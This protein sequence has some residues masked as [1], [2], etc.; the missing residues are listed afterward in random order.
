MD[1]PATQKPASFAHHAVLLSHLLININTN[2]W[3]G[4]QFCMQF[5]SHQA[6]WGEVTFGTGFNNIHTPALQQHTWFLASHQINTTPT[7]TDRRFSLPL[8]FLFNFD[9]SLGSVQ[10][11]DYS[12]EN[13]RYE[14]GKNCM[15]IVIWTNQC[16]YI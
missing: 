6:L 11:R 8:H 9:A 1:P 3:R 15:N 14:I 5:D 2:R 4:V 16:F 10:D 7:S 13:Y 12:V